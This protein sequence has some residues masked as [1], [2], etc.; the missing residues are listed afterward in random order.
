[1]VRGRR[2]ER[3]RLAEGAGRTRFAPGVKQLEQGGQDRGQGVHQR[4]GTGRGGV[5]VWLS[6]GATLRMG[7]GIHGLRSGMGAACPQSLG[8]AG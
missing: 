7:A 6:Q 5:Q 3:D 2:Q 8:V 4:Q 1:M